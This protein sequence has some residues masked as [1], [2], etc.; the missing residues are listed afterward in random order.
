MTSLVA[1]VG[2]DQ[3]GPAS[4]NIATDSRISWGSKLSWDVGRKAFASRT[5]ADIFEYVG[6]VEFAVT[7]LTQ[8]VDAIEDGF[9]PQDAASK[10]AWLQERAELAFKA[11]PQ[12]RQKDALLVFGTREGARMSSVF[13]LYTLELTRSS[14]VP[15]CLDVP[16]ISSVLVLE[17][18]GRASVSKWQARWDSSSQG[19][20]SRA[21]FSAFCDALS[22]ASDE[23][24][25][26]APQLV[27]LYR[28][29]T[30]KTFGTFYNGSSWFNGVAVEASPSHSALPLEWRNRLFERCDSLGVR[31]P[32]AQRHH[33]PNGLGK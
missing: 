15:I 21:V 11:L 20:T 29:G 19:G 30:A 1:W 10:F 4:L 7:V 13:R 24:S 26:G 3:R 17:G 6:Q 27:G 28:I 14:V 18:S 31:L 22:A 5:T 23:N 9:A 8:I 25:G 16:G 2:A 12:D 32:S 33:A